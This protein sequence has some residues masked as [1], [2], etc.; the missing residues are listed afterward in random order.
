[1]SKT[2]SH[3]PF[4]AQVSDSPRE[5]HDHAKGYCDLPTLEAWGK[6]SKKQQ[7]AWKSCTW[8]PSNWHTYKGF[9]RSKG[10]R[11]WMDQERKHKDS[12]RG[13]DDYDY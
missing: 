13:K 1:M 3:R 8:Q 4:K 2:D 10:E 6:M 12:K 5:Y 9:G 11:F 7:R